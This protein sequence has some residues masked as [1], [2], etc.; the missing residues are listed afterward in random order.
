M[1]W[2]EGGVI[3]ELGQQVETQS[4]GLVGVARVD[5]DR[6]ADPLRDLRA[7]LGGHARRPSHEANCEIGGRFVSM[8]LREGR[9]A[10]DVGKQERVE[11]SGEA[12][13]V[14]VCGV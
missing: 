11:R 6:V 8:P 10:G 2:R 14:A 1:N 12:V 5:H 3:A 4:H 9:V 7:V 13:S